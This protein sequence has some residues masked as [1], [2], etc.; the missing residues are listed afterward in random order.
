MKRGRGRPP[1]Y[2]GNQRRRVA[3]AL[4]KFG[5]TKGLAFLKEH[6][7]IVSQTLAYDV[8]VEKGIT[9]VRGRPKAA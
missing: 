3:T 1:V 5:L 6:G 8:A 4:R 7:L 2:N 9:F